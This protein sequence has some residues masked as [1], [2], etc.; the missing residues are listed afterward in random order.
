MKGLLFT[1]APTHGAGAAR[2]REGLLVLPDCRPLPV[3]SPET[4]VP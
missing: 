3:C 2:P 1:Y 4:L